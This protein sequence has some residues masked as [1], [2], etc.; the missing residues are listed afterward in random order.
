MWNSSG[1]FG[2]TGRCWHGA[3][4]H[5]ALEMRREQREKDGGGEQEGQ[6]AGLGS[7]SGVAAGDMDQRLLPTPLL[8]VCALS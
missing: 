6:G 1:W 4:A 5:P 7:P 8:L 2:G 3:G